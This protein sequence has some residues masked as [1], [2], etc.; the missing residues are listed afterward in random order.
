M[1]NLRPKTDVPGFRVG[2]TEDTP[3][4]ALDP[5]SLAPTYDPS[6]PISDGSSPAQA[7]QQPPPALQPAAAGDLRCEGMRGGCEN[8]VIGEAQPRIAWKVAIYA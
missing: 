5:N 8:G 7:P 1:F 2:E 3:G 6:A 4:F